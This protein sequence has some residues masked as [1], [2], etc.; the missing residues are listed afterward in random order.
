M[1]DFDA[2]V[3]GAGPAGSVAAKL[4]GEQGASVLL[5]DRAPFPRWKVCGACLSRGALS[6]LASVGLDDLVARLGGVPLTQLALRAPGVSASVRLDGSVAVSRAELDSALVRAAQDAG[7]TFWPSARAEVGG[8]EAGGRAVKISRAGSMERVSARVVVDASGLG[9]ATRAKAGA[10]IGLGCELT[11]PSYPVAAGILHMVVARSGYVG[12]VRVESGTMN[13]AAAIDPDTVARSGPRD[14]VSALLVG[15]GMPPLSADVA[16][17][18]RGTPPLT[19]IGGDYGAEC[20]FRVGD[21]AG[22]VEPFT[23]Q[24]M[25]WAVADGRAV[26]ALASRGIESWQGSLLEEWRAYR[27]ARRR[28]SERLCRT[29]AWGLRRPWL[30]EASV[31]LLG[32]VPSL[33]VPVVGRAGRAPDPL[34][35][36]PA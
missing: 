6:Q 7:V 15:A 14:A 11:A 16:G 26:A 10:R 8:L 5:V 30:V 29:L 2:V 31:R 18:W 34:V 1:T 20:L 22:Y 24:G 4:L 23:G 17:E 35:Q 33:A 28:R 36:V 27:G 19:R 25:S 12:L 32:L 3:V 21:A 13:I 9:R